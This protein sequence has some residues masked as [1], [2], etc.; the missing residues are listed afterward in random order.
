MQFLQEL[1]ALSEADVTTAAQM[2][3]HRD[4]LKTKNKKY[5]KYHPK[6]KLKE[7]TTTSDKQD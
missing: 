2:V 6:K 4:Y 7:S 5:R 3:Y 1:L